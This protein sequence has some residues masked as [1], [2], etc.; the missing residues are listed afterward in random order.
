MRKSCE[1]DRDKLWT[2]LVDI[3]KATSKKAS[4]KS[5][6]RNYETTRKITGE[7]CVTQAE[8]LEETLEESKRKFL[9]NN[10]GRSV[11]VVP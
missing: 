9:E 11:E 1:K 6:E 4:K 7:I 3:P 2:T 5:P 10:T 8:T